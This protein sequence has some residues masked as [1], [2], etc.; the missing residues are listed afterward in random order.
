MTSTI[1]T[2]AADRQHRS[3]KSD[4][5]GLRDAFTPARFARRC[6]AR[7]RCAN[8]QST[9]PPEWAGRIAPT[10]SGAISEETETTLERHRAAAAPIRLKRSSHSV[11][12]PIVHCRAH[13]I[14]RRRRREDEPR[15]GRFSA[16]RSGVPAARFVARW[17]EK[18]EAGDDRPAPALTE[19]FAGAGCKMPTIMRARNR[20][21]LLTLLSIV[22][23]GWRDH[24]SRPAAQRPPNFIVVYADD[25]GYADIG[26]FSTPHRCRTPEHAEP[27][28]DGG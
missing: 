16:A 24:T 19:S 14:S 8:P 17:G 22:G 28:S 27:G 18:R 1:L 4:R 7:H 2:N 11:V 10:L 5:L 20:W 12:E 25:M 26:S 21:I 9:R 15:K 6:A 23:F 3:P 13:Y